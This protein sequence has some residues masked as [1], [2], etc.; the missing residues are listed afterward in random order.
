MTIK[1]VL[2]WADAHQRRTGDWPTSNS[3]TVHLSSGD[4]WIVVN[5]ALVAGIR[6]LPGGSSLARFLEQRRGV[7]NIHHLPRLTIKQILK[8]ADAHHKRTRRWPRQ[9]SGPIPRSGGDTWHRIDSALSMGGRGLRAG[10]SLPKVL[11]RHRGVRNIGDLPALRIHQILRWADSH[12]KRTGKWP[13]LR[14]GA[15]PEAPGEK[16]GVINAALAQGA[17]GLR[18]GSSL[19][20]LLSKHRGV[21]NISD[22]PKL[23]TK[24]ILKWADA[25]YKR[26]KEWPNQESGKIPGTGG[27]SWASIQYALKK[28]TRGMSGAW[29]LFRFLKRY[30]YPERGL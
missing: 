4:S 26:E 20:R 9:D 18:H 8:W 28:G 6:G 1:Q 23:S 16:W 22:L 27:E 30:R 11:D 19:P 15:L 13:T 2:A 25:Y 10:N 29:S 5:A 12:H 3:G 14:G 21:R 17:R 7:R 24:Q